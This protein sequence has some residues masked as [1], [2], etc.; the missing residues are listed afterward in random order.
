MSQLSSFN[1]FDDKQN[2]KIHKFASEQN[3]E[4]RHFGILKIAQNEILLF[5]KF[6][7][8]SIPIFTTRGLLMATFRSPREL[9]HRLG[10]CM[11]PRWLNSGFGFD[12]F[13]AQDSKCPAQIMRLIFCRAPYCTPPSRRYTRPLPHHTQERKTKQP[14]HDCRHP[15]PKKKKLRQ[16]LRQCLLALR[17]HWRYSRH[18][19]RQHF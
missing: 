17:Q 19:S 14:K 5:R 16:Y 7:I 18:D 2:R 10:L 12:A 6:T 4:N 8:L 3:L 15:P 11:C 9:T 13:A 1:E